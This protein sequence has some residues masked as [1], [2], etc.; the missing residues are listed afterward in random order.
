MNKEATIDRQHYYDRKYLRRERMFS[1]VEQIELVKEYVRQDDSI[2]EIGKGNGFVQ[3]FLQTYLGYDVKTVDVNESLQPEIVDDIVNPQKLKPKSCDVVLCYEVLEH[4]PFEQSVKAVRNMADIARRY[5]I[6]SLP[7]MRYFF[8]LRAV[9]FGTLPVSFARLL[10]TRRFRKRSKKFGDD[11]HWEIGIEWGGTEY[12]EEY[13]CRELFKD[14][15]LEKHYRDIHVPW[16]H[17][18]VVR[19]G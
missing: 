1:F 14:L 5:V 12:S 13:V 10:S 7:D 11:H 19:V 15:K 18:F 9:L 2:V 17:Y 8:S 6:I 4:M 16:H 3:S